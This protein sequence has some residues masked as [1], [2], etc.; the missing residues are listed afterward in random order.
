MNNY[1]DRFAFIKVLVPF[2]KPELFAEGMSNNYNL[3]EEDNS[4]MKYSVGAKWE[5][6]KPEKI[7][8]LN[9]GQIFIGVSK[10]DSCAREYI[11]IAK[12]QEGESVWYPISGP[13]DAEPVIIVYELEGEKYV[14]L[15][16]SELNA[17]LQKLAALCEPGKFYLSATVSGELVP[18]FGVNKDN[19]EDDDDWDW[20]DV[21]DDDDE[22]GDDDEEP[23][24]HD[25]DDF[26][27]IDCV[28]TCIE[29]EGEKKFITVAKGLTL[30]D[31]L[32]EL[33]HDM[34]HHVEEMD[35]IKQH[36]EDLKA[37]QR[38]TVALIGKFDEAF[39]HFKQVNNI[40]FMKPGETVA[41]MVNK[42]DMLPTVE[43]N[44]THDEPEVIIQDRDTGEILD[45]SKIEVQMTPL[46][47]EL[48][49]KEAA[50]KAA[51]EVEQPEPKVDPDG[52]DPFTKPDDLEDT[53]T[54]KD[55]FAG[56]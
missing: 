36:I 52:E 29:V 26:G 34:E 50:A 27:T 22:E 51:D 18:I 40:D 37:K 8:E 46:L 56:W 47:K 6:F 30:S 17:T 3:E 7:N 23:N 45:N 55:K 24:M 11:V 25:D 42:D 10:T 35:S 5:E 1:L 53:P 43:V 14:P 9:I 15:F 4:C 31:E 41:D 49:A 44:S 19:D 21:E 38:K 39:S 13:G 2:D 28:F 32:L 16:T 20:S 33:D 54:D 48:H 12:S